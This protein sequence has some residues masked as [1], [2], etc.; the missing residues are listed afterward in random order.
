MAKEN[1]S[2]GKPGRPG[3]G[4]SGLFKEFLRQFLP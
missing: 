1:E 3:S 4:G 2:S